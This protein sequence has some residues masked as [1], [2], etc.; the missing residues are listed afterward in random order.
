M[1]NTNTEIFNDDIKSCL[2]ILRQGGLI[3]YPTDT[4]W[5]IG[6]DATNDAAVEKIFK[7]KNRSESKSLI[8]LVS[9]EAMLN[10]CVQNVPAVAWDII[11]YSEKPV[12]IIY[13][14]ISRISEKAI[15]ED[16]TAAIRLVKDS[17]CKMLIHKFGKPIISTS[18]NMSDRPSPAVFNDIEHSILSGV[19]YVVKYRQQENT[20]HTASSIIR[21]LNNGE[22]KV[23]RK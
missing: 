3:V 13:E 14:K 18:A 6:C 2:E 16:G 7:L 8:T 11:E 21:I 22:V 17:F 10:R 12:T 5:G 23:I 15:A 20:K 9:D 4:I 19:D 1:K